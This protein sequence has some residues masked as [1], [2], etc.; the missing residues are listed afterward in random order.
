MRYLSRVLFAVFFLGLFVACS[1]DSVKTSSYAASEDPK[2]AQKTNGE[3]CSKANE[4]LGGACKLIYS[5]YSLCASM[6]GA[7]CEF[8]GDCE[9]G[10][11]G[12]SNKCELA[13][14]GIQC[15]N[16]DDCS[17]DYCHDNRCGRVRLDMACGKDVDCYSFSCVSK[18]CVNGILKNEERCRYD[19]QCASLYCKD[20]NSCVAMEPHLGEGSYCYSKA[21]CRAGLSCIDKTCQ[22]PN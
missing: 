17:S 11:C 4:C 15:Q 2:P 8:S 19:E 20:F 16:N 5:G 13:T 10:T 22:W 7:S 6:I 12:S 21:A 3:G 18:I 1:Q 14:I 9:K